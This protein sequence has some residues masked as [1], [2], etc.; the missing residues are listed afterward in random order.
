[1]E[2]INLKLSPREVT[3][4]KV[5]RLRRDGV[6]PVHFYGRGTEALALQVEAAVLRRI[7]PRVGTSVPLTVELDGK[8]DEN[9]CFVREVQRHPVTDDLLHV[10]FVRVEATQVVTVEVPIILS[11]E[12]LAVRDMGGT[13]VQPLQTL[14]VEALPM[15]MPASF[16]L[17]VSVLE[18]FEKSLRVSDIQVSPD[19]TVLNEAEE[20]IARVLPPRIEEEPEVV[21]EELEGLEGEE[22]VEGEEAAEGA[23]GQAPETKAEAG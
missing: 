1:M 6:I 14:S 18:D 11:G 3:G 13:V 21:G 2:T 15:N 17:D 12:S 10:D 16:A 19:V 22:P 5:K 20:M 9:I 4:K 7:L 8:G 23:E